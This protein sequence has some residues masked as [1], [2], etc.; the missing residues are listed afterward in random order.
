MAS[1]QRFLT[2]WFDLGKIPD[3]TEPSKILER[4]LTEQYQTSQVNSSFYYT[5]R[6]IYTDV[7]DLLLLIRAE[8]SH[9]AID[10]S[11]YLQQSAK[12]RCLLYP[13]STVYE[14]ARIEY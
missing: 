13:D 7:T 5:A 3:S 8:L 11:L 12:S 4:T 9:K 1:T 6:L 10:V 2:V 14:A